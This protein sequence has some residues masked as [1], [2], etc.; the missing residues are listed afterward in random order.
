M[1][2]NIQKT[3]FKTPYATGIQRKVD[4]KAA[5]NGIKGLV[6]THPSIPLTL[7]VPKKYRV[8]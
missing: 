7:A 1:V 2:L 8:M 5:N 3:E 6:E 4:G